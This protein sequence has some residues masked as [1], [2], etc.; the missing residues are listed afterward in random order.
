MTDRLKGL[1][2]TFEQDIRTDDAQGIIDAIKHIRGVASVDTSV[3]N[4]EDHMN[5]VMVSREIRTKIFDALK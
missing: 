5:R 4:I 1:I 3:T 2:V